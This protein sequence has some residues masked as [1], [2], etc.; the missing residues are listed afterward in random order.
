MAIYFLRANRRAA[1]LT[2]RGELAPR[3]KGGKP[4]QYWLLRVLSGLSESETQEGDVSTWEVPKAY[5]PA[6]ARLFRIR[7]VPLVP[8][9]PNSVAA[10]KKSVLERQAPTL[11]TTAEICTAEGYK[12]T[13]GGF[14]DLS[15]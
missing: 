1:V 13:D 5:L 10:R 3:S 12:D 8:L 2:V 9:P 6:L 4:Q 14:H 7:G 15:G 11:N